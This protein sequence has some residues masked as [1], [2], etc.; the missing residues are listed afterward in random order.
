MNS[1][2]AYVLAAI[3]VAPLLS[4]AC[5]ST[6]ADTHTQ[7]LQD[8]TKVCQAGQQVCMKFA[9]SS[10]DV[11]T[12]LREKQ[13]SIDESRCSKSCDLQCADQPSPALKSDNQ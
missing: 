5:Q 12:S 7:C 1:W 4:I 10:H 6:G 11:Y 13:C 2:R 9:D 8:C 3:A